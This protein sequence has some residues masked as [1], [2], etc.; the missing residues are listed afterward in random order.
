MA[1]YNQLWELNLDRALDA[2][3]P[4]SVRLEAMNWI[5]REVGEPLTTDDRLDAICEELRRDLDR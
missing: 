1:D 5:D 4:R 2:S 3:S